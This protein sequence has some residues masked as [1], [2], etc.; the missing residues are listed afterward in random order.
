MIFAGAIGDAILEV[1]G[2]ILTDG[3]NG[4]AVEVLED[5]FNDVVAQEA[6]ASG[7]EDGTQEERGRWRGHSS[8]DSRWFSHVRVEPMKGQRSRCKSS[9]RG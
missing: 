1:D 3:D 2:E 7:H 8:P 4:A 9:R 6:T 5:G